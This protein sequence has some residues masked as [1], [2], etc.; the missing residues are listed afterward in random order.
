MSYTRSARRLIFEPSTTAF[1]C[2]AEGA[3]PAPHQI[4][5]RKD[6]HGAMLLTSSRQAEELIDTAC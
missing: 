1:G 2:S 6:V 5:L 4:E 3:P